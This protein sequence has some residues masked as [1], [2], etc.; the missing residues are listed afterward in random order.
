[1][2]QPVSPRIDV[3]N[4]FKWSINCVANLLE[5]PLGILWVRVAKKVSRSKKLGM[6]GIKW[7]SLGL[8]ETC[9]E[10]VTNSQKFHWLWEFIVDPPKNWWFW[11][12]TLFIKLMHPLFSSVGNCELRCSHAISARNIGFHFAAY[13]A[14]KKIGAFAEWTLWRESIPIY[15]RAVHP[16]KRVNSTPHS[17]LSIV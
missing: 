2:R 6:P 10:K 7:N 13:V 4:G 15:E 14:P 16:A 5:S 12:H 3:L 11:K 1:M 17:H 8:R 9:M